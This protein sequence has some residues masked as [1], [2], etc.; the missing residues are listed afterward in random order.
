MGRSGECFGTVQQRL[1]KR[2]AKGKGILGRRPIGKLVNPNR[3]KPVSSSQQNPVSAGQPNPVSPGQQNSVS[4]GQPNPVSA[5]EATLAC[6]SIP[7]S[8]SA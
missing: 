1:A 5:G 6:N 7:L 2:N 4:A 8:V 3:P